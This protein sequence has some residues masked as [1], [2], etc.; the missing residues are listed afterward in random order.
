MLTATLGV[1]A[2]DGIYERPC[3][4]VDICTWSG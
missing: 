3:A 2:A 4:D 1:V